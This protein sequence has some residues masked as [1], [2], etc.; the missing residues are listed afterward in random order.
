MNVFADREL[1]LCLRDDP[2][3]LAVADAVAETQRAP[4]RRVARRRALAAAA[5][6]I[7]TLL[8]V[9]SHGV[10]RGL[11]DWVRGQ[12]APQAV[13]E[14]F[15]SPALPLGSR[16][17]AG[18]AVLVAVDGEARLYST[19]D[20][21]GSYCLVLI[22]PGR[23][24]GDGGT[25]IPPTWSSRPL[26]AG[27]LGATAGDD[28]ASVHFVAGRSRH[29]RARTIRFADPGG[30][31]IVR[32]IAY[33]GFFL[34]AVRGPRSACGAADWSPTFTVL[35]AKGAELARAPI[36]LLFSHAAPGVCASIPPHPPASG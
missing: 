17:D 24:T 3:L 13:V 26:I 27:T 1:L 22:A 9:P 19:P 2:R 10:A 35:D 6:M 31:A 28:E 4:R 34:A 32:P 21:Q 15:A 36:T 33:D 16:P 11:I 7:A 23:P 12:P 5:A 8:A 14:D 20:D 30:A 25:C 29:E 18:A